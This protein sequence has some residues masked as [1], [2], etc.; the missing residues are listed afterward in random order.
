M[1]RIET[2]RI[3]QRM[4]EFRDMKRFVRFVR[5]KHVEEWGDTEE[6]KDFSNDD[7]E[8]D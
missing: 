4:A 8:L 7:P 2:P 5:D 3:I 6:F 1:V